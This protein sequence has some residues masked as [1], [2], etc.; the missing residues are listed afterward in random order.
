MRKCSSGRRWSGWSRSCRRGRTRR[1]CGH[2][3]PG[4]PWEGEVA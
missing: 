3:P 2:C 1:S 4:P